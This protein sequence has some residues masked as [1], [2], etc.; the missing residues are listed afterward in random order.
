VCFAGQ[1]GCIAIVMRI[2][3]SCDYSHLYNHLH[4]F[5]TSC[6]WPSKVFM[7][8]WGSLIRKRLLRY[9]PFFDLPPGRSDVSLVDSLSEK[10]T[11]KLESWGGILQSQVDGKTREMYS[12]PNLNDKDRK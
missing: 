4:P 10:K 12:N 9:S 8:W 6:A 7:T 2:I 11:G 1:R 3:S 5:I